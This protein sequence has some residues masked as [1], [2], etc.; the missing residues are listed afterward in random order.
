LTL[1]NNGNHLIPPRSTAKEYQLDEANHVAT[2]AWYYE[3]P[4]V[5]GY[6]VNGPATGSVQRL[7]N[8]N[9][10]ISWGT[11]NTHPDRPAFTEVDSSGNITWELHFDQAGQK[12]YRVHKYVWDPCAPIDFTY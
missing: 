11:N 10:L 4:P 6:G 3:H 1:Y 5:G 8:G 2:L 7:P 9:T 12:A